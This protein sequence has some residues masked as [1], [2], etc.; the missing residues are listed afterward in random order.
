MFFHITNCLIYL[1]Y[2]DP[3]EL[4]D[5]LVEELP[6]DDLDD[7][8]ELV[9]TE[10]ERVV[11]DELLVY[12]DELPELLFLS[13]DD[14]LFLLVPVVEF[15]LLYCVFILLLRDVFPVEVLLL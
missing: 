5:E 9:L 4:L 3:L 13:Y 10:E 11:P 7:E 1:L 8:E 14:E 15:S 2:P 12:E 6:E